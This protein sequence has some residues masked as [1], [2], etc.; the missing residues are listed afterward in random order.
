MWKP[1]DGKE[2]DIFENYTRPECLEERERDLGTDE[3]GEKCRYQIMQGY[4]S[5]IKNYVVY[6]PNNWKPLKCIKHNQICISIRS[7]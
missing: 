2:H 5:H 3:D 1:S 6:H 4:F 7:L